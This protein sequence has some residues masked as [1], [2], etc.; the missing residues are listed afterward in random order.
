MLL[1]VGPIG[2]FLGLSD[3]LLDLACSLSF[4]RFLASAAENIVGAEARFGV[5]NSGS[6][7]FFVV[8]KNQNLLSS[9][10][11]GDIKLLLASY[12][13]TR[14]GLADQNA[15]DRAP[16]GGMASP[17]AK[18]ICTSPEKTDTGI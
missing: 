3:R 14:E 5:G 18:Y 6:Q 2:F 12:C 8:G 10:R 7:L 13:Q 11:S 4:F 9:S 16:L 1:L 15:I 17:I